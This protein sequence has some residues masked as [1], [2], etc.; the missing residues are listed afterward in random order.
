MWVP[1]E[2]NIKPHGSV[3]TFPENLG[4]IQGSVLW[5]GCRA[6]Q[7]LLQETSVSAV[8]TP[9][10]HVLAREP[11]MFRAVFSVLGN[12]ICCVLSV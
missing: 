7:L 2:R 11:V 9:Y 8:K 10:Q 5:V 12:C 3:E 4:A 6:A 1:S